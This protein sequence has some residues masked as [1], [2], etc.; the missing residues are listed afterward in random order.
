MPDTAEIK[1]EGLEYAQLIVPVVLSIVA[2][3]FLF[4]Q[5]DDSK[6]INNE[7]I[8]N[9]QIAS[10]ANQKA[11]ISAFDSDFSSIRSNQSNFSSTQS[12]FEGKLQNFLDRLIPIEQ[13]TS[14]NLISIA[15]LNQHL[16]STDGNITSFFNAL[17]SANAS[18]AANFTSINAG[19]TDL[20]NQI[21]D[22]R[23]STYTNYTEMRSWFVAMDS[24]QTILNSSM[25]LILNQQAVMQNRTDA[26]NAT[27]LNMT[28]NI[29]A[30]LNRLDAMNAT[31]QKICANLTG[32]C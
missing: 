9:E 25:Q 31:M 4:P 5:Y 18:Y 24:N 30:I 26:M 14:T 27:D 12:F 16:T 1:R 29:I 32:V 23:N 17:S 7:N 20:Q 10:L 2:V 13:N 8:L 22:F 6:I 21:T 19:I 28:A 15:G 11:N 3:Y